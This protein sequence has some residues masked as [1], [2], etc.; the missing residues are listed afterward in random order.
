MISRFGSTTNWRRC[1]SGWR[2]RPRVRKNG[3]GSS[4]RCRSQTREVLA[5]ASHA[6]L[7][8]RPIIDDLLH[9]LEEAR[10]ADALAKLAAL[11]PRALG[12]DVYRDVAVGEGRDELEAAWPTTS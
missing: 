1:H 2:L 8:A 4:A 6:L 3:E 11:Q 7:G 5:H 9:V 10:L 12:V